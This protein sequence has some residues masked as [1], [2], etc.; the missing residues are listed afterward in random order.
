M[1]GVSWVTE[2]GGNP[3]VPLNFVMLVLA[4]SSKGGG[5]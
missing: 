4:I 1:G 3:E 2:P 5:V